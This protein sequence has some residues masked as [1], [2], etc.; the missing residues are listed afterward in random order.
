MPIANHGRRDTTTLRFTCE[1]ADCP[2]FTVKI[3]QHEGMTMLTKA[4]VTG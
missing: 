1:T 2:E 3:E 4:A